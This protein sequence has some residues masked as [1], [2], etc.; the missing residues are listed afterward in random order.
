[1]LPKD[2]LEPYRTKFANICFE[3]QKIIID[4]FDE[5]FNKYSHAYHRTIKMVPAKVKPIIYVA[6]SKK[7]W[8]TL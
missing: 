6:F 5:I 7:I 1:M 4:K 3:Y 2:L 8:K